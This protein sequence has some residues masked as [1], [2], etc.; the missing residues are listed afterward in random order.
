MK[1]MRG[2]ALE[3]SKE[4]NIEVFEPNALRHN[5]PYN[6]RVKR[7]HHTSEMHAPEPAQP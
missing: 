3:G 7:L 6:T 4:G 5:I 2:E 1:F